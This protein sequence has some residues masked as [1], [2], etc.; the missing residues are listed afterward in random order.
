MSSETV[1]RL[2]VIDF[3]K[4]ELKP[5]S[6]EWDLVKFQ[7]REALEDYCS[8]EAS[9]DKVAELFISHKPYLG[10]HDA[11]AKLLRESE[12]H[13]PGNIDQGLTNILWPQGNISFRKPVE[14][15]TQLAVGLEKTIRGMVLESFGVE[16]YMDELI[17][18][19]NY[20]LR[21]IKYGKP[22]TDNE[23]TLGAD[24][25]TEKGWIVGKLNE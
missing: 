18:A 24:A 13:V 10:Y 14:S 22:Q 6:P 7:F 11:T 1:V 4:Q 3:S 15:F 8:F 20:N 17:D 12:A 5:G 21:V 9:F 23:P 16:K 2:P 19:A 25:H